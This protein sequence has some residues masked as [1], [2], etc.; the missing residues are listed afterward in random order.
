MI[1]RVTV[2]HPPTK[3]RRWETRRAKMLI[4][5][6]VFALSVAPM[7]VNPITSMECS[8]VNTHLYVDVSLT[9]TSCEVAFGSD[10]K[11]EH[12][13]AFVRYM[14][15]A[16]DLTVDLISAPEPVTMPT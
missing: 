1:V 12:I 13:D 7:T 8:I 6:V 4:R 11:T 14:K 5:R 15:N 10:W 3:H 2:T 9:Q 16:K